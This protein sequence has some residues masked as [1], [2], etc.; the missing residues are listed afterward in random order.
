MEGF[1][2]ECKNRAALRQDALN[3]KRGGGVVLYIL[4]TTSNISVEM[5]SNPQKLNQFGLEST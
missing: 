1:N 3:T 4:L 2:F 5:T